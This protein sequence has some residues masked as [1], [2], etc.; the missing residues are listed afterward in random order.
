MSKEENEEEANDEE[1]SNGTATPDEP[2][3]EQEQ[4]EEKQHG[5]VSSNATAAAAWPMLHQG[6]ALDELTIDPFTLSE[7]LRLHILSSGVRIGKLNSESNELLIH[8]AEFSNVHSSDR[9]SNATRYW[10]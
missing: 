10:S 6:M 4:E 2:E 8:F 9:S 5:H 3:A 1:S 7:I